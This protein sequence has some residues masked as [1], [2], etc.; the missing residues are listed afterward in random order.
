MHGTVVRQGSYDHHERSYRMRV[1]KMGHISTRTNRH[2]KTTPIMLDE[3]LRKE[4]VEK[5]KILGA[6]IFNKLV[7]HYT[8]LY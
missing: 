2:I 4:V 7:D 8:K 6:D 3:Y 1:S 5:V